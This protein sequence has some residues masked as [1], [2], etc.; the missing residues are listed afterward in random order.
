[1]PLDPRRPGRPVDLRGVTAL[2]LAL[3]ATGCNDQKIGVVRNPPSVTI[4][5]PSPDTEF[6]EGQTIEFE[7]LV[8]AYDPD[9][10]LTTITHRWVSGNETLCPDPEDDEAEDFFGSDGYGYCDYAFTSTGTKTIQVTATDSRGDRSQAEVS[11]EIIDNTPPEI[12]ILSPEDGTYIATDELEVLEAL[13][14]DLEDD[15]QN[16]VITIESNIEGLVEDSATADSNG[17]YAGPLNI[18][19]P[20]AHL[21]TVRAEDSFG[22]SAQDTITVNVYEHGPPSADSVRITPNPADTNDQLTA[23]VEGWVDLDESDEAYRFEWYIIPADAGDTGAVEEIDISETTASYPSGKTAKGDLIRVVAYPYNEYGEG[24][25]VSS[26]TLE[27][28]NSPPTVPT[29]SI[30]P[31]LPEPNDNLLCQVDTPSLDDDGDFVSY[32]YAWYQNGVLTTETTN[33]VSSA[34]TANADVWECVVTPFDGEDNGPSATASITVLDVTP[35]DPPV[36]D[37]PTRYTNEEDVNL[38]G[39]C[40]ADC[41]LTIYC[42]DSATSWTDVSTCQSD[43]TFSYTDVFTRG[44]TTTCYAECEDAS[45][46]LS[47]TSNTVTVEVCDPEDTY[48]D[49]AGYGDTASNAVTGFG[50]LADD[51]TTTVSIEG[52][53][54]GTD[55]VDWYTISTSDDVA[56]DRSAGIDYYRFQVQM[57]DGSSTYQMEVFKGGYAAGNQECASSTGLTEYEDSVEDDGYYIDDTT[58]HAHA[59]PSEVRACGNGSV[60]YNNCEDMSNTYYVRIERRSSTVSS[61]QGYELEVTNGVW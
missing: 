30:S 47:N 43:D 21:L 40:E 38:T 31:A 2:A 25:G 23:E 1:M 45:G 59:I 46:N 15:P 11:V 24:D 57:L 8:E 5:A 54:L 3:A 27:I 36:I 42:S 41:T 44:D 35:P 51:G 26:A 52:N 60:S 17:D 49:S 7:A 34:V 28:S 19:T 22:Q 48:E 53:I 55:A 20:G 14:S 37:T 10:D 4:T 9:A 61:C 56:A 58:P 29:I 50:T 39:D 18:S 13:V 12:E 32:L 16:L 33:V 6:Y